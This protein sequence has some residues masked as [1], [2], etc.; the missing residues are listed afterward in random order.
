MGW[1]VVLVLG[2]ACAPAERDP[3]S[4]RDGEAPRANGWR[5][6]IKFEDPSAA[7]AVLDARWE[8]PE[9]SLSLAGSTARRAL[10]GSDDDL[11]ALGD[12]AAARSGYL[13]PDLT[14]LVRVDVPEH[15]SQDTI[16]AVTRQLR[17]T[18]GVEFVVLRGDPPPPPVD[19]EP[20]TPS[21]LDGQG[22]LLSDPGIDVLGARAMGY[23]GAGVR[24]SDVEYGWNAEH[25]ELNELDLHPE[26][27]QTVAEQALAR[28][29]APDHGTAAIGMLVAAPGRYGIDGI[30][31][32]LEIYTFPEWTEEEGFRREAAV[33]A[34]VLQ[35]RPGDIVMLELQIGEALTGKLAP[36][37]VE[38]DIWMLTRMATDAGVIVVAAAGNGALDLDG[39]ELAY[40][41]SW[42]DSGALLV[43]A[44]DPLSHAALPFATHGSRVDL[45][46]WGSDVFTLG[47]GDFARYGDDDDQAYTASFEGS[48]SA[49]PM[50]AGAAALM[51]Q[52]SRESRGQAPQPLD[53]RRTLVATGIAQ[54]AGP[55]IGPLPD[56]P[57]AVAAITQPDPDAPGVSIVEP[58]EDAQ[59][60][61]DLDSV[62]SIDV[63]VAVEDDSPIYRVAL[64]L[65][66]EPW[67]AFDEA[68]PYRFEGVSLPPGSWS[69]RAVATDVWGNTA[70]SPPRQVT[71]VLD[72]S[73]SS[74][75]TGMSMSEPEDHGT[76]PTET[77]SE[78]S[79]AGSDSGSG[80]CSVSRAAREGAARW[81]LW[82][83][84]VGLGRRRRRAEPAG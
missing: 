61:V 26:P 63:T 11:Q 27:G 69:L 15:W 80:G 1:G 47:Y 41:R 36:A 25:E 58:A 84:V 34:A 7:Q 33:A 12:R 10:G 75:G 35:S 18:A 42:G 81:W 78:T 53:V 16:D 28:G 76:S 32:D 3:V 60:Q 13:Q 9:L 59:V 49:V 8:T 56:L 70:F 22:Y 67:G 6:V 65:E 48:S 31:P 82:G 52:A 44:G 38:E 54:G 57:A 37:E 29:Y 40:Y 19:L 23:S 20:P 51:V 62:F 72:P 45:Q 71:V 50:V 79:A 21:L 74:S 39:D 66:G 68:P 14:T 5:W 4:L 83:W 24:L 30:A 55:H 64:Q 77:T 2:G 73:G 43:G 46:G 17:G